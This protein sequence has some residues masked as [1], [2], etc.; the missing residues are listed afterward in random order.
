MES[1]M[2]DDEDWIPEEFER[3]VRIGGEKCDCCGKTPED[4]GLENLLKCGNCGKAYYCGRQC[5]RKQWKAG[6]KM[7]CR[8]PGEFQSGDFFRLHGFDILPKTLLKLGVTNGTL[9]QVVR[10]HPDSK[11][12][13]KVRAHGGIELLIGSENMEQL[14][15]VK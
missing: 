3:L 14:R 15:P 9:A 10:E 5:Q 2:E 6:H 4:L 7:C 13:W 8:K 11:G 1:M 12:R